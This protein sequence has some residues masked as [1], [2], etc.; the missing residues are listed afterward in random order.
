MNPNRTMDNV[1]RQKTKNTKYVLKC[2]RPPQ[3]DRK[4]IVFALQSSQNKNIVPV[5]PGVWYGS[6]HLINRSLFVSAL[7]K[8]GV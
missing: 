2:L 6:E 5:N 8:T 7:S 4:L 1:N 3:N